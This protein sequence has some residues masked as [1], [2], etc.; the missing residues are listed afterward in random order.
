MS[1]IKVDIPCNDGSIIRLKT[2][3][4]IA[5]EADREYEDRA[6]ATAIKM[7]EDALEFVRGQHDRR[8]T[9]VAIAFTFSDRAYASHI[10]TDADNYGSLI[11][12][13]DDCHYRLLKHT[14]EG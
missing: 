12:A 7:L 4:E 10:P 3:L 11:A 14:N 5:A 9:G 8:V 13:V 1:D 6:H 2:R